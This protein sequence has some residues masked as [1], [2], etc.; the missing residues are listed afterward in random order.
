MSYRKEIR[1]KAIIVPVVRSPELKFLT[2]RDSRHQEWIFV[3]GG[4]K[5]SEVEYPLKCGLRELEEETRG[6]VNIKSGEFVE[7]QF[8]SN[9][10]SPEETRKDRSEGIIV[11]LVYHVYIINLNIT[12]EEQQAWDATDK[13]TQ[14]QLVRTA[15][16]IHANTGHR[17]PESLAR[18][19]RQ[20]GAPL[21]S[22]AAM[23]NVKC[24][25]CEEHRK[26][27]GGPP[28]TWASET[29]PWRTLGID[30]KDYNCGRQ[31]R[32]TM[33][34]NKDNVKKGKSWRW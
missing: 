18:L 12:Q 27:D 11:T 32:T 14:E 28:A 13:K 4:C 30:L 26:P 16:K 22:R 24:D 25:A 34:I 17:N 10:R 3:T 19:L 23:E 31:K 5:K 33:M 9:Y 8:E 21:I 15:R 29:V 6:V 7:F 1:H 2:V 20:K